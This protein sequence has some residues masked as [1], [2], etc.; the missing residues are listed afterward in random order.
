MKG[1]RIY[2]RIAVLRGERKISRQEL[3]D[4]VGVNVQTVGLS[5]I[6]I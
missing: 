3:A 6:H 5:L 4:I 1:R 2:N